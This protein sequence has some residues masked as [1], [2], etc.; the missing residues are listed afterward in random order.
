MDPLRCPACG[1]QMRI[2]SFIEETKTIDRIIHHLESTFKAEQPPPPHQQELLMAAEKKV[3]YF[4]GFFGCFVLTQGKG[5]F[6]AGWF[7]SFG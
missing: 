3:E 4:K 6:Q 1:G 7:D 5:L 2:I